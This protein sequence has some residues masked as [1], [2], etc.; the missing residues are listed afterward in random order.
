MKDEARSKKKR[1]HRR[2][3]GET[4]RRA[5]AEFLTIP[6]LVIA[7]CLFLAVGTYALDQSEIQILEPLRAVL[8]GRIFRDAKAT[9]DLLST[10][11]GSLITVTSIT[12][13]LLLLAVQQSAATL[14]P[15]VYDQFLR[16]RINQNDGDVQRWEKIRDRIHR[17]VCR[18]GY[19]RKKK[20]FTQSYGSDQLDSSILMMP[21]V[22]F[23]PASDERV[24]TTIEAV[25][26]DLTRDGL[27]LR[28]R[29]EK[30]DG[31]G[32]PGREG[33]FLPCSFW[34]VDCLHPLGRDEEA[35]TLSNACSACATMSVF[36]PRNMIRSRNG[37]SGTFRRRFRTSRW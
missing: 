12:F 19:N 14:T 4:L 35:R 1:I 27:V 29:P 5:F 30:N 17:Q 33:V 32:L 24:R 15:Q 18:R 2:R 26:R 9:S 34:L 20:A 13:S 10:I 36:S 11:G 31:D 25:Q 23:L 22:G 6:S 8:R 3:I 37:S 16:R 7:G 28:Y 21:L